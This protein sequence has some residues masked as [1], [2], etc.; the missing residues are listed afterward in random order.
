MRER[1]GVR[2]RRYSKGAYF[3]DV[4]LV[5]RVQVPQRTREARFNSSA[6]LK[7]LPLRNTL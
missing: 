4:A 1:G 2:F 6:H 7:D 5:F 3:L